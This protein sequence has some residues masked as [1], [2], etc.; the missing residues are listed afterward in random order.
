V[1][2]LQVVPVPGDAILRETTA[3]RRP[4]RRRNSEK[5]DTFIEL[6]MILLPLI[7]LI[8]GLLDYSLAIFVK[9]TLYHAAREGV[10]YAVTQQTGGGGQ[11]AAI[12]DVVRQ[13][14]MGFIPTGTTGDSYIH[15][16]YSD[17][18]GNPV[19]GVGSN[20][21]GNILTVTITA[22]PW[23]FFLPLWRAPML[24]FNAS[25]ADAMEAPPNNVLPGR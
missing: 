19:N 24:S 3:R 22:Y 16:D 1:T 10:R 12:R 7:A 4:V 23:T 6:A 21:A 9:N 18:L 13:N 25:S 11:D 20:Q 2:N 15:L 14:A 17:R 5:G 8:F